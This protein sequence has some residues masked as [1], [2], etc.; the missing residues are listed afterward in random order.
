MNK[1]KVL[2]LELCKDL[3]QVIGIVK[4][5]LFIEKVIIDLDEVLSEEH[6]EFGIPIL[7]VHVFSFQLLELQ[8]IVLLLFKQSGSSTSWQVT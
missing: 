8:S 1:V 5:K 3:I 7:F 6:F 4:A 2:L